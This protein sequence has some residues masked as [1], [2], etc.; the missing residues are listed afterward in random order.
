MT[1][2]TYSS[3]FPTAFP[4]DGSFNGGE[5][6]AF[7]TKLSPAGNSLAYS[8]YLGGSDYDIGSGIAVDLA[9]SP[10]VTG[11]TYSSDF[12][13]ASPFDGS[14]NG[15][16]DAVVTKLSPAGNSLAYS[17]YLGGSNNDY[18][19]GIAVDLAGS[20]YVTGYTYSSDFP[21]ASPFDTS[22]N[23]GYD[24][25]VTK[26]SDVTTPIY[27]IVLV[28]GWT[29]HAS[30]WNAMKDFL[31]ADGFDP[32]YIWPI[33]LEG[34]GAPEE[35]NF[36]RIEFQFGTIPKIVIDPL[37]MFKGNAMLLAD[38]IEARLDLLAPDI[39]SRID[40]ID[41]VA[42]SMG[43]L[44]S[45][46]YLNPRFGDT[47][48]PFP[49]RNLIMLGT[50]NNGS[51]LG[52][53][54]A[55]ALKQQT[56]GGCPDIVNQVAWR[57]IGHNE[58]SVFNEEFPYS[59]PSST[60]YSVVWGSRV[61]G[62]LLHIWD[63][64]Y[65][66]ATAALLSPPHDGVVTGKSAI[67]SYT[68][69]LFLEYFAYSRNWPVD[70]CHSD[71]PASPEVYN[72]YVKPILLDQLMPSARQPMAVDTTEPQICLS[73]ADSLA[74]GAAD[75]GTF[76]VEP[77]AEMAVQC[78]ILDSF[79]NLILRSPSGVS[80]NSGSST[81]DSSIF[82]QGETGVAA[83]Y[84]KIAE[85]GVWRWYLSNGGSHTLPV[86]Y[87]IFAT[88][89][90]P[91]IVNSSQS[92]DLMTKD[93]TLVIRI[94]AYLGG[95]PVSGLDI[96]VLPIANGFDSGAV[97]ILIDD[98][99]HGDLSTNDGTYGARLIGLDSG[100]IR[101]RVSLTGSASGDQVNRFIDLNTFVTSGCC[102]GTTGNVN[103]SVSE[104]P[105]LSDLSL[106]VSY[107]TMMP[108]PSMPCTAEANVNGLGSL[109]LSDLSRLIAYLTVT[110]RPVLPSCP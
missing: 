75:S 16:Y 52:G 20:P 101:L 90:S 76:I 35:A 46:R 61:S 9:G 60:R 31:T 27:P 72:S 68:R 104:P 98:G 43:G 11:Y 50:P 15:T 56:L 32:A 1:G 18:G 73:I 87:E 66:G 59:T 94:A 89:R 100:F 62:P 39:R 93:D 38:S 64:C 81:P 58:M 47:W 14:L 70:L 19:S 57:E 85:K 110:P 82:Y 23:G 10:Y 96:E 26:F 78:A 71:L 4:F 51:K 88:V 97:A 12:P 109:D 44:I 42:H 8:T 86:P 45:R 79:P 53:T 34:C 95:S 55:A 36:E 69:G 91:F 107:L 63:P 33:E 92:S 83:Y 102:V 29:A 7:V 103:K 99:I 37:L 13:T 41:I 3:D 5:S 65:Y 84:F 48:T 2:Y 74:V 54:L 30:G 24:A 40:S 105:D 108:R 67:G 21:T 49:V 17:T 106:L 77:G 28:H 6:D 22:G 25:F 80:Y